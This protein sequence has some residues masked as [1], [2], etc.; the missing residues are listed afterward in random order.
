M[1][2]IILSKCLL[3]HLKIIQNSKSG[4]PSAHASQKVEQRPHLN[5]LLVIVHSPINKVHAFL[6]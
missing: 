4:K 3:I 1:S 5:K 6:F 2:K